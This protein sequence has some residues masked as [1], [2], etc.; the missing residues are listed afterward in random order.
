MP[1]LKQMEHT[2]TQGDP[3]ITAANGTAVLMTSIYT[4]KT[5]RHTAIR[6][7]PEDIL[8]AYLDTGSGSTE[9]VATNTYQLIV[10]DPNQLT[11]EILSQGQYTVIKEFQDRNKTKKLGL[12]RLVKSDYY[13]ILQVKAATVLVVAYCTFQLTCLR[14]VETL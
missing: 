13:I 5:P 10:Q 11:T 2:I 3:N 9:A 8:S 7:R 6:M 4:Y 12:M 14:Y 1:Q